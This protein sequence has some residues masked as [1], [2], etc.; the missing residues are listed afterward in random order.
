MNNQ[1]SDIMNAL[2]SEPLANQRML[3]QLS[4]HSLGVVNRS[5][6]NLMKDGYVNDQMDLTEKAIELFDHSAPR[7]AVILAAGFGMRM[8]PINLET[9]K[10]F[11]EVHG[12]RLI[13]RL[14]R[15]LHE[16][17][18]TQIYVVV[19]FMKERFEYLID[20]FGVE[21]VVNPE[22][23]TKN[24][25]HSLKLAAEHLS[26]TYIVPCDIWCEKN[27]FSAYELYSWYMVSDRMD[28]ESAVRV[29]RKMELVSVSRSAEGNAMVGIC[30]LLEEDA[31]AVK[32]N[33]LRLSQNA[34]SDELF[35]EEALY[36]DGGM[37]IQAKVV[38]SGS[39]ME[40][41]TYEQLR[42]LDSNSNQ[43]KSD[44]ISVIAQ[45]LNAD[46]EDVTDISV[47]KKGMTNR[48]FLFSCRGKKYIMR[49]SGEGTDQLINREEE[50]AV[51]QQIRDKHICDEIVYINPCNGYKI[52]EY[53]EGARVCD[54]TSTDDLK[55]CMKCLR[56][57][58][59]L[60]LQVEHEFDIFRQIEFYESL[61]NGV[62][63]GYADYQRTKERVFS[64][65]PYINAHRNQKV[66]TH[67]DAVPD[68]FL[69][70]PDDK[71]E[72]AIRLIDWEYAGMQDPHVDIAM[73]CIYSMYD[74]A[75][76]DRLIDIY[77]E[78]ECLEDTRVKIYCYIAAC[79]LLW[80]NWCEY[81]RSLGVEFGEYS[82]RQ[83]RYAK[84]YYK[85]V[86]DK[87]TEMEGKE[88]E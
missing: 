57:F 6:K 54:P 12:E 34:R 19:G 59:E 32:G 18:I 16:V 63:S 3:A 10:A 74:K 66:L 47:L 69:F 60:G 37:M 75:Q 55:K 35:W 65:K 40:I 53:L 43:L 70:A 5:I 58:H 2:R 83:Y 61:W 56:Q 13:E 30:Y 80:S 50:A 4:G 62:P 77:F 27:P 33:I 52:T 8:V 73:F 15:Q 24:N 26:N 48:S 79:G 64:L 85:I 49:I 72:E 14:I 76:V 86:R 67:I 41:N 20:D 82:L 17:G 39:V 29:N 45:A 84:D 9:P 68:N 25:L 28:K 7:S 23:S 38:D 46:C 81:K 22:Y 11:V 1:E 51:Y 21:L 87:L 71:G 78:N 36:E 31:Q 42:E 88:S 44:A